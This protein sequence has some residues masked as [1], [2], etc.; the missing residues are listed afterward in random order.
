MER[1]S[2][3]ALRASL[4][5]LGAAALL[6]GCGGGTPDPVVDKDG[7]L[8]L[9]LDEYRIRP[10]AIKVRS[11]RIR[12]L[13]RNEGRLTHNVTV[14]EATDEEGATP[15]VYGRTETMQPGTS[16]PGVTVRLF[17]GHYRLV[18]TIG[19]HENLGQYAELTVTQAPP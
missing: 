12:L 15:I 4:A 14:E 19:N 7:T 3:P 1:V 6:A 8:R 9:R 2:P 18:C 17:P 5:L 11:G 10:T 13:A 16:A